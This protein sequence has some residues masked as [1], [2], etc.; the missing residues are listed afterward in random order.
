[1]IAAMQRDAVGDRAHA[2]LAHAVVDVAAVERVGAQRLGRAPLR[3]VAAGEVG[4]PADQLRQYRRERLERQLRRLAGR[5]GFAL[6]RRP[7]SSAARSV[8]A[9]AG[10]S[11]A[12]DATLQLRGLMRE[13]LRA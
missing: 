3:Q 1:M 13:T 9:Y 8:A 12:R 10:G 6:G 11:V 7:L 4:R 5:D 2:E